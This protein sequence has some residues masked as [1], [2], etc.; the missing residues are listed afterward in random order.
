[1]ND[2]DPYAT[3]EDSDFSLEDEDPS[4]GPSVDDSDSD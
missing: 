3:D 2:E 4:N 1:M